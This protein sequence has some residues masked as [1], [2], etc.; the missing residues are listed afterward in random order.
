MSAVYNSSAAHASGAAPVGVSE[1][2]AIEVAN[3]VRAVLDG[4]WLAVG[5]V[6][7]RGAVGGCGLIISFVVLAVQV[8]CVNNR[9]FCESMKPGNHETRK[10]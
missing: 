1:T 3:G 7:F 5:S 2:R 6:R 8:R 9:I 4:W 10:P